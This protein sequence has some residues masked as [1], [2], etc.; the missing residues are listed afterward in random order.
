MFIAASRR[1]TGSLP[2]PPFAV[3]IGDTL[4]RSESSVNHG[5]QQFALSFNRT[6]VHLYPFSSLLDSASESLDLEKIVG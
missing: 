3:Q 2:D 1:K 5:F 6:A 4:N